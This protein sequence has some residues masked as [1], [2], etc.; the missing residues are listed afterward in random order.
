M[1]FT[2]AGQC[3]LFWFFLVSRQCRETASH[4]LDS[5]ATQTPVVSS[6]DSL[7]S[8][9]PNGPAL[10]QR[11]TV[12]LQYQMDMSVF[13]TYS[14]KIRGVTGFLM[15]VPQQT[16]CSVFKTHFKAPV[17]W[18][19]ETGPRA[20]QS[21]K[22]DGHDDAH[23]HREPGC[24]REAPFSFQLSPP[25]TQHPSTHGGRSVNAISP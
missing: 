23:Q 12:P 3:F 14:T 16:Q 25:R 1:Q 8:K 4:L 21:G 13:Q 18:C 15:P 24:S 19:P 11:R 2:E 10:V 6:W 22:A 5:E 9:S 20:R 17:V 7:F